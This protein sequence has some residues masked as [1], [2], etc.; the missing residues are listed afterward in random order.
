MAWQQ[1]RRGR[2]RHGM[3]KAKSPSKQ[4]SKPPSRASGQRSVLCSVEQ[5]EGGGSL[6][7]CALNPLVAVPGC[8]PFANPPSA[9]RSL[10]QEIQ[11]PGCGRCGVH[12]PLSL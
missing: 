1:G 11:R 2:A 9:R 5:T 4:A 12:A 6:E 10:A 3:G 7:T 8:E